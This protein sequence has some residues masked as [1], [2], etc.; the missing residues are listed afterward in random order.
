MTPPK[1]L[2]PEEEIQDLLKKLLVLQLFQLNVSQSLI[3]KKLKIDIN[4][5][6]E[7]LKGIKKN[8]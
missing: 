2:T 5:V 6:N 1:K 8:A 4:A 3:A 7:L